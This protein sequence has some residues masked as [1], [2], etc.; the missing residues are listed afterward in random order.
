MWCVSF[1]V[2]L[3][4]HNVFK[5]LPSGHPENCD[6]LKKETAPC[7]QMWFKLWVQREKVIRWRREEMTRIWKF[8]PFCRHCH[9]SLFLTIYH[10]SYIIEG[11]T[12]SFLNTFY[13][14]CGVV[15][16]ES[17]QTPSHH[18]WWALGSVNECI[19]PST[20]TTLNLRLKNTSR[21]RNF[22]FEYSLSGVECVVNFYESPQTHSRH[23]WWALT[24]TNDPTPHRPYWRLNLLLSDY[25]FLAIDLPLK[26]CFWTMYGITLVSK[27]IMMA[28]HELLTSSE[29]MAFDFMPLEK[30]FER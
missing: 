19:V 23:L 20:V 2:K 1:R 4:S 8:P 15:F 28:S 14:G 13:Y 27:R 16:H 7:R 21:L 18:M 3:A 30:R 11:C 26:Y 6:T 10:R 24:L 12:I 25:V 9:R 17:P 22:C 29:K 5:K